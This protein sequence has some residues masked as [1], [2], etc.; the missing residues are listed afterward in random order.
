MCRRPTWLPGLRKNPVDGAEYIRQDPR[1]VALLRYISA[2][3]DLS[4][5]KEMLRAL[6]DNKRHEVYGSHLEEYFSRQNGDALV[7]SAGGGLL[8]L[9]TSRS[10]ATHVTNVERSR[11]L[12]RMTKQIIS[13]NTDIECTKKIKLISSILQTLK[14]RSDSDGPTEEGQGEAMPTAPHLEY[15]DKRAD[16]L[17]TD[18]IDHRILGLGLLKAV[19]YAAE[20]LLAPSASVF[21]ARIKIVAQLVE[22]KL[23]P[24]E[25]F[26]LSAMDSYRWYPGDEKVDMESLQYRALSQP[27]TARILDLQERIARSQTKKTNEDDK[28]LDW[29]FDEDIEVHVTNTGD[30]NAVA[31]WFELSFGSEETYSLTSGPQAS[32]NRPE[33]SSIVIAKSWGQAMQ[34]LDNRKL[35][36]GSTVALRVQQDTSQII[37][38]S[39]PAPYRMRHALVPRWHY[40]MIL[41]SERNTAYAKAIE[42]AVAFKKS[43]GS[44]VVHALDMGAGSGLLSMLAARA[45]AD[46]TYAAEMSSH[47]C[48]VAEECT[49]MNGFLEKILVLDRDVRRMDV[50]RKPDGTAPELERP[51]D[52][53]VFEVFDSGLIGEGVLHILAAARSK[54]LMKDAVL[55][56][57]RAEVYAQPIQMRIEEVRGFNVRQANR[58]RWRPDYEGVELGKSKEKW[59]PLSPPEQA[60]SFDFYDIERCAIE[61]KN[62]L[63]FQIDRDGVCNAVIMWFRLHLDDDISLNTSPYEEKGPTWQQAIQYIEET[64]VSNGDN[65]Q[66]DASHDTYSISFSLHEPSVGRRT[67]VPLVDPVWKITYD[68]LQGFNSQIVKS[69]VQNPLEYRFVSQSAVQFAARPEDFEVDSSQASEFCAKLM[70]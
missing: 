3:A 40:D 10:G 44:R 31:F 36:M 60:F 69:C 21:P 13:D 54:L 46:Y 35:M 67:D 24:V 25:G 42:K 61:N 11:M 48:D 37:F 32:Y 38:S 33:D 34:Y 43:A 50:L 29:E 68:S 4:H 49:I 20:H 30:W 19:D 53:A 45:G 55:V 65:L 6:E 39:H 9:E 16:V 15:M 47:M 8:G 27:F 2:L 26:N 59:V 62:L 66:I 28:Q 41:D 17:V 52:L 58:W 5:P 63:N 7:L 56:P 12:Y 22:L 57:C 70:G 23:D 1:R 14:L 18:L 51:V 64:N